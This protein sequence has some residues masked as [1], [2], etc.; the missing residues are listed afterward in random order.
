MI[1]EEVAFQKWSFVDK[2]DLDTDHWYVRLDGGKYHNV[3]FRFMKVSL[4]MDA[5]QIDFDYEVV[6]Y[7]MAD[8]PHGEPQFTEAAG[9]ILKSILDDAAL[10]QDYIIGP[11]TGDK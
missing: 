7:P 2:Q 4:N 10:Q 11:K 5:Q 1:A 6:E 3:I 8:D 9:D